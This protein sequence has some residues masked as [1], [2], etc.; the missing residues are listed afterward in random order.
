MVG[1]NILSKRLVV[2]LVLVTTAILVY[3]FVVSD[4]MP[5][6]S[7]D[8]EI[9]LDSLLTFDVSDSLLLSDDFFQ[10]FEMAKTMAFESGDK[11]LLAKVYSKEG[12]VYKRQNK[13]S[14]SIIAF[15]SALNQY[16]SL[17]DLRGFANT[18][19]ELADLY[20]LIGEYKSS[21]SYC[22]LGIKAAN[23][24][25]L[26]D[27]LRRLYRLTGSAYKYLEE[28]DK[29]LKYYHYSL[30][31]SYKT[32]NPSSISVSLN[33]IG[34]AYE[35]MG[36]DSLALDYFQR[37]FEAL[38][39]MAN[40]NELSIYHNNAASMYLRLGL[41][42]EAYAFLRLALDYRKMLPSKR[43]EATIYHNFGNYF[44]LSGKADSSIFYLKK[45][46]AIGNQFSYKD[47]SSQS[48]HLLSQV[49]LQMGDFKNAYNA[50]NEHYKFKE[51]LLLAQRDI[52]LSRVEVIVYDAQERV[53]A[54]GQKRI[55][56]LRHFVVI[57]SVSLVILLMVFIIGY[58]RNRI[59]Y[60]RERGNQL[61][62]E[63]EAINEN[64]E[65]S[66]KELLTFTLQ[67]A[68]R[69]E[70]E[71]NFADT[72]KERMKIAGKEAREHLSQLLKES[73]SEAIH[74]NIWNEF[75]HRFNK[76]N[77]TFYTRL[78]EKHANL[79]H[80]EKRLCAFLLLDMSTKEIASLTGQM[81][82]SI[83]IA[84]TRLRKKLGISNSEI[85]IT[86]YLSSL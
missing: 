78:Y 47:R 67:L 52:E 5:I 82:H 26:S 14:R 73:T 25:K 54:E 23:E 39:N 18:C 81:P 16:N 1:I 63:K 42:S 10:R 37:S 17:S 53:K 30:E 20:K 83:N 70:A 7:D 64:L 66:N 11:K 15:K 28:F 77:S 71:R 31:L 46:I 56:F 4:R 32:A 19:I 38:E 12:E 9:R 40:P 85:G 80:N 24:A 68:Q 69:K 79:T 74:E 84:R 34:T 65:S 48:L 55:A 2:L 58:Y 51:S 8:I 60:Y 76:V 3:F 36:K 50:L 29:S 27:Q 49:Y 43:Q 41:L 13:Y 22:E 61:K 6:K 62:K 57:L 59:W 21:L 72:I 86:E 45:A 75:E 33:N 35:R 44:Y